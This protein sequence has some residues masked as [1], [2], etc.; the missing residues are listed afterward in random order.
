MA[1]RPVSE[2][3]LVD[4][5]DLASGQEAEANRH[6]RPRPNGTTSHAPEIQPGTQSRPRT[7][8]RPATTQARAKAPEKRGPASAPPSARADAGPSRRTEPTATV[9]AKIGIP[10]AYAVAA[11]CGVMLGRA[12][13][14][15]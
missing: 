4:L 11:A 7:S 1:L 14:R 8:E 15:R 13:I 2:L 6:A 10:A 12:A 9:A 3:G 5:T